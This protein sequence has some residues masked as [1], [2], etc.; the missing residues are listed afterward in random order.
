MNRTAVVQIPE[1]Q[2][3]RL[4]QPFYRSGSSAPGGSGLGLSIC[5]EIMTAQGG[6][7]EVRSSPGAGTRVIL[8]FQDPR[9]PQDWYRGM[10][11]RI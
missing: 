9:A 11:R 6:D 8:Y 5:K 1:D 3:D 4:F 2:L 7:I 10:A